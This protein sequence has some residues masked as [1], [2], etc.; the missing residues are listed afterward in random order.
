[1]GY[2]LP[3]KGGFLFPEFVDAHLNHL[4][5]LTPES[6]F[7]FLKSKGPPVKIFFS[8]HEGDPLSHGGAG[9]DQRW[10]A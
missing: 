3:A 5:Y 9:D 4:R 2:F 6:L 8:F 7:I 10:G 1:M